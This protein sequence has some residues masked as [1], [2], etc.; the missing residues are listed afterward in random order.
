M[1]GKFYCQ[2]IVT[3]NFLRYTFPDVIFSRFQT[4]FPYTPDAAVVALLFKF[5]ELQELVTFSPLETEV[6][7]LEA[8]KSGSQTCQVDDF[9]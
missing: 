2:D 9:A 5:K 7:F 4:S 8:V 3:Q 6:I 1:Y